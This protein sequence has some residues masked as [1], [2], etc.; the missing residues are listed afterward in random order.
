MRYLKSFNER[1]K[2]SS[3]LIISQD[4]NSMKHLRSF[5]ENS[6]INI[7]TQD[8]ENHIMDIFQDII[9]E[10][11]L[12]KSKFLLS[13][14]GLFVADNSGYKLRIGINV[15]KLLNDKKFKSD[16]ENF[17]KRLNLD[18]FY[19]KIEYRS[20]YLFYID[21]YKFEQYQTTLFNENQSLLNFEQE[22][23]DDIL[24]MFQDIVDEFNLTKLKR[25]RFFSLLEIGEY[26]YILEYDMGGAQ[27]LK[28]YANCINADSRIEFQ[29][30]NKRLNSIGYNVSMKES[31]DFS[32]A[33]GGVLFTLI[34]RKNG[35]TLDDFSMLESEGYMKHLKSFN[36]SNENQFTQE[37]IDNIK[38]IFQDLVDE[39]D[40]FKSTESLSAMHLSTNRQYDIDDDA[41]IVPGVP[42]VCW[43]GNIV[44]F[45]SIGDDNS[46]KLKIWINI[47]DLKRNRKFIYDVKNF[48][49]R[50]ELDGFN[51]RIMSSKI[52][53][54]PLDSE[55]YLV[56]E[57]NKLI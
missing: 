28:I 17:K 15:T 30:F 13:T 51:I 43:I 7:I 49:K 31:N 18:G 23:I 46:S 5:N 55:A 32:D 35:I 10:Y 16:I 50:I 37:E 42:T 27:Y 25:Q 6:D 38:D 1:S 19:F 41:G 36:E 56:I 22:E 8:D 21:I 57:I 9:D 45:G 26:S 29:N 44:A 12:E 24:D 14:T 20:K 47:T 53:G 39:Y 4:I 40:L 11:D 54:K 34:I 33:I 2:F 48:A 3:E 52:K